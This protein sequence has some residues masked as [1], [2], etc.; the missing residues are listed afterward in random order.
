MPLRLRII[1]LTIVVAALLLMIKMVD[2]IQGGQ[3]LSESLL[4]SRV[5]AQTGEATPPAKPTETASAA[6]PGATPAVDPA[7]APADAASNDAGTAAAATPGDKPAEKKEEKK[8]EKKGNPNVSDTPG[9]ITERRFTDVELDLLQK[10]SARREELDAWAANLQ[11]KEAALDATEKRI[12]DKIAQVEA[13]KKAVSEALAE[14]NKI[15]DAQVSSLVKIYENMKP[16]DAARIFDELERPI[17]LLIVD[18]MSEKKAAPI[19]AAMDPKR[20]KVLTVDLADQ[21]RLKTN[22]INDA[23]KQQGTTPAT[24]APAAPAPAATPA[25][26]ASTPPA[27]PPASAPN[28]SK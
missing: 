2:L 15:E 18:K 1:P 23:A 17:L 14:Y 3:K 25:P 26:A 6:T 4:I 19:L 8:A 27:P 12:D 5:E 9:D 20:A 16:A 7:T 13:M 24:P 21:R 11:I 22:P 10:L 28:P